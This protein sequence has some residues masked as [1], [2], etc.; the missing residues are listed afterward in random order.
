VRQGFGL[1]IV[2]ELTK[3]VTGFI[4]ICTSYMQLCR[5]IYLLLRFEE[6]STWDDDIME[7]LR[8]RDVSEECTENHWR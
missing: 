3:F 8:E 6:V 1:T 4:V 5:Y 7:L 2:I